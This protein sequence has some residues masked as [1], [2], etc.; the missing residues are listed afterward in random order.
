[1]AEKKAKKERKGERATGGPAWGVLLRSLALTVLSGVMVFMSYPNF[2][3][4]ELFPL[5]WF[6][7][8]PLLWVIRGARP[9]AAFGWGLVTGFVTNA[10]GFYWINGMLQDFGHMPLW[11]SVP[12][13]GLLAVYQGLVFAAW[14]AGSVMAVRSGRVPLLIAAPVVFVVAELLIP[15]VFPW[16]LA[17]GQVRFIP[18]IQ[19]TDVFGVAG[20]TFL[21]VL[22]NTAI[23][24][25]V[26]ALATG[27]RVPRR[28]LGVAAA[29]FAAALAYGFVRVAQVDAAM[30]A[31]PKLKIGLVE[32]NIGIWE[33][34]ARSLPPEMQAPTLMH[35]LI[36]HQR[37][38]AELAQQGAD[39]IVWPE[40]S[41]IPIRDTAIKRTDT[42]GFAVGARGTLIDR[43]PRDW[44]APATTLP[45]ALGGKTLNAV[46][47]SSETF[48]VAV[49][50]GGMALRW[51]GRTWAAEAT[52]TDHTLLGVWASRAMVPLS[53]P[54]PR[55]WAVGE[56]G[57]IVGW[58]EGAWAVEEAGGA[59]TLRAVASS[60]DGYAFAVGDGGALWQRQDGRWSRFGTVGGGRRLDAAWMAPDAS[61]GVVAGQGGAVATLKKG[62]GWRS[63][64]VPGAR[65][66]RGV[67]GRDA[68]HVWVVG[69]GGF[70]ARRSG[71][72]WV[73]EASGTATTLRAV[74]GDEAG[75]VFAVGDGGTVL[76]RERDGTWTRQP[77]PLATDLL[78]VAGVGYVLDTN[79]PRDVRWLYQSPEPLPVVESPTGKDAVVA[80]WNADRGLPL[81]DRNAV[82]RGFRTPVL[83]GALTYEPDPANPTGRPR[84]YNAALLIDAEGRVLG[85][86]DKNY[87]LVFGEYIPFGDTFPVLYDWL[88]EA[89][90]FEAGTTVETFPFA[91]AQLG[92][93]ICYEDI[94][95]GFTSRLA[96]KNP[97]VI[98][99]VTNDAWFGKTPEPYLHLALAMFRAV[100][101]RMWLVR[102]TNTGVSAYVDAVGRLRHATRL[103]DAEIALLEVPM[104]DISSPYRR[105]GDVFSIACLLALVLFA[106]HGIAT[107]RAG[108]GRRKKR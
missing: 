90:H 42:F 54:A 77:S 95:P 68:A 3:G 58:R 78:G 106:V 20:L 100:E 27:R 107:A 41:Y 64:T 10:G 36:L 101:N 44:V 19:I 34:E 57:A 94:L 91:G 76:E 89:G 74:S 9:R 67:W 30:E 11:A 49:G 69:D 8:V 75:R 63:S 14:T 1:M 61:L 6:A 102:S 71:D 66:L 79:V 62:E 35:N 15:F 104:M 21:L 97:N 86:Y 32:G 46:A 81:R 70:I 65:H 37:L 24:Q 33:K 103:E 7:L 99:N 80:E 56:G 83:L 12:I 87:L 39:L 31:A 59:D 13:T 98:I 2:V 96:D 22:V 51:D 93:M 52:G 29:F 5:Q 45:P 85:S 38:S 92:V 16:Y 108:G 18:I 88:P 60:Y 23:F 105:L 25:A 55:A 47:A 73:P 82:Q 50:Y 72:S 26:E 53:K 48:A 4:W 84:L 43:G 40:S 28:A 17:N